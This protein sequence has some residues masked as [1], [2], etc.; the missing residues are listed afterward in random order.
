M[1]DLSSRKSELRSQ[2]RNARRELDATTRTRAAQHLAHNVSTLP[3]W[4]QSRSLALYLP[5][6]SEIDTAPLARLA[7]AAGTEL[8]LPV[9][10]A[11]NKLTF[12]LWQTDKGLICNRF[13]IAE[14]GA[15]APRKS[16]GAIDLV[17]LPLVAWDSSGER[18]GMGGGFYDRTLAGVTGPLK[19]GL[20]Y[21]IQHRH[22]LPHEPWD[23]SLDYVATEAALYRC[24][25]RE[26]QN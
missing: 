7:R 18:L 19:V 21:E 24:H 8:Y 3:S 9:I 12:A 11:G 2:I 10:E 22:A 17:C 6:D 16:I 23:I 4:S 15:D 25:G 13:G 5:Q 14:P 20:A 1:P 26:S